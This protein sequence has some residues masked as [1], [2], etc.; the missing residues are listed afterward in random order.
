MCNYARAALTAILSIAAVPAAQAE[1]DFFINGQTG[2]IDL[3]DTVFSD[4][5]TDIQ[6]FTLGY[7]WRADS[8]VQVGAEAGIGKIDDL[9]ENYHEVYE[10]AEY[11][12]RLT[13]ESDHVHVG[14][15]ARFQFGSNS[16]WFAIARLGYLTYDEKVTVQSEYY[17]SWT[18]T[19]NSDSDSYNDDGGG[20]YFGAGIGIDINALFNVSLMHS[21]YAYSPEFGEEDSDADDFYTASSTTLGF[22]V[23]F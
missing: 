10:D 5:K 18:G 7:R 3:K 21:G 17:D 8:I 13:M 22:E 9:N 15:N 14:A 16:R 12:S 4:S 2:Q 11:A 6:T 1:G 20:V 23:R 19:T